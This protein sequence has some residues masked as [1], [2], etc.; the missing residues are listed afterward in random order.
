MHYIFQKQHS[1]QS[2]QYWITKFGH[3]TTFKANNI[4]LLSPGIAN[5]I[6]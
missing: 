5:Y 6:S 4:K 2:N 1:I 3:I